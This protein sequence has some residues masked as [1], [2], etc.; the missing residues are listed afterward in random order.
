MLSREECLSILELPASANKYEVE[1][2][3]MMLVKRYRGK[4]DPETIAIMDKITMA[5]NILTDRYV[6]PKPEDPRLQEVVLGRT[7]KQWRNL[8]DYGKFPALII[9]LAIAMVTYFVY[10]IATNE[11]PQFQIGFVGQFGQAGEVEQQVADYVTQVFPEYD[12][13]EVLPL[14]MDLSSLVGTDATDE[15]QVADQNL[16]NYI[17]K[18]LTILVGDNYE[19]FVLD[20]AAFDY[21]A[22][23]EAFY[24]MDDFYEMLKSELP[25]DVMA[26]VQPLERAMRD[27]EDTEYDGEI[28]ETKTPAGELETLIYGL[29]VTALGLSEGLG[30]YTP[31]RTIITIGVNTDKLEDAKTF[32]RSWIEDYE[33]MAQ[34]KAEI[35]AEMASENAA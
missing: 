6:E 8:W 31:D 12:N 13:I 28:Q 23:Q 24:V 26:Q 9:L 7:R 33:Q 30:F 27:S 14:P 15:A 20:E 3:Y 32:V 25:A 1:N 10:E 16:Y 22:P 21:Y 18:M 4:S 17:M 19:I 35:E 34:Q 2:R 5:Y 11:K 29:D